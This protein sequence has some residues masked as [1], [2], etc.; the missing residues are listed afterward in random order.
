MKLTFKFKLNILIFFNW[1][2]LLFLYL[3]LLFISDALSNSEESNSSKN[4]IITY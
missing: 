4:F 1:N 3:A 2:K